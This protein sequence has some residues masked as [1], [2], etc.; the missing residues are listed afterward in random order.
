M[1]QLARSQMNG[2]WVW[3]RDAAGARGR[4]QRVRAV[5]CDCSDAQAPP[6][7]LTFPRLCAF[8]SLR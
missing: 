3:R 8:A 6:P 7:Y 2:Y 4:K 1:A 5:R